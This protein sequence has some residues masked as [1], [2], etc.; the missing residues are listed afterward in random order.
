MRDGCLEG[1]A[2]TSRVPVAFPLPA[3]A[4]RSSDSRRGVGPSSRSAYRRRPQA[5]SGPRRGYRVPH[6]RAATG[7]GAPYTPGTAVL[8]P[9]EGRAQP[10]PAARRRPVPITLLPHPTD[11]ALLHEASTRVHAIRPSGLPWP[12]A[13]RVE[14][15]ALGLLPGLRTPPL[16]AT[17]AEDGTGRQ[18]RTW[19]NALRHQPSLQSC[20]FTRCVRPRVAPSNPG[21]SAGAARRLRSRVS[22]SGT[23]LLDAGDAAGKVLATD[24]RASMS[25]GARGMAAIVRLARG[26][27][28]L[29]VANVDAAS[30]IRW[31]RL[32]KRPSCWS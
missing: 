28:H 16:P 15:A 9:A 21:A 31:S 19:N 22:D 27:A 4:S 26:N 12:V 10:A 11:R 5:R 32:A 2:I 24:D 14:R 18:A 20:V 25:A 17:H 7:V 1:A 13:A 30:S 8:I 3:F 29:A 6:A 23:N